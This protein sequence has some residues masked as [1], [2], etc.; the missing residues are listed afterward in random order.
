MISRS[1]GNARNNCSPCRTTRSRQPKNFVL[2]E[3][4]DESLHSDVVRKRGLYDAFVE[5]L[6][7]VNL[8]KEYG[9]YVTPVISPVEA[10][11]KPVF[12]I[13]WLIVAIGGFLGFSSGAGWAYIAD[14]VDRTFRTPE[15]VRQL[16]ALPIVGDIPSI[17][18]AV[19]SQGS[20]NG[21]EL[22]AIDPK[23]VA[24]HRP[25]SPEAEA[26]RALR[27]ALCS[28]SRG[29]QQK[30]IQ[31]TS[32]TSGDGKS[33]LVSNLAASLAQS[34][35]KVLLVDADLRQPMIAKT[36]AIDGAVGLSAVL[37][38]ETDLPDV[39]QSVGIR[40]LAI[41]PA[42]YCPPNPS[43]L[44]LS[45]EFERFL[46]VVRE[47]YD[48]VLLDSPPILSFADSLEIAARADGVFLTIRIYRNGRRRRSSRSG[49]STP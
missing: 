46:A 49:C 38:G 12:P 15:E 28:T 37:R 17:R 5:R 31:V 2:A 24:C 48:Y 47:Q 26:I 11:R 30:V 32:P 19:E 21:R 16:L 4:R 13:L 40:N 22:P 43:E 8:I 14:R 1:W 35:K 25:R 33:I 23:V 41:L 27:T 3:I 9:G 18:A 36:F 6:K 20:A 42:G 45:P 29:D 44:L 39:V 10:S 34:G 7:R